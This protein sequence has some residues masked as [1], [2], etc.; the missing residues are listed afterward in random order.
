VHSAGPTIEQQARV[1][2]QQEQT[3]P[4]TPVIAV[5]QGTCRRPFFFLH[6]DWTG[7]AFYCFTLARATG[8][9]QPFYAVEP[10]KIDEHHLPFS[11]E[12]MAA[13]HLASL[14]AVQP[15][16]PYLLGGFCN[17]GLVAY[18]MAR[19]LRAEGEQVDLLLVA[20]DLPAHFKW[21]RDAFRHLGLLI[22]VSQKRQMEWFLRLRH[23]Q[24]HVYRYVHPSS[25]KV[26]GFEKVL[27]VDS[28]L[29]TMFPAG[30]ALR[31][32]YEGVLAWLNAGYLPA[33]Y[34][35]EITVFWTQEEPGTRTAWRKVARIKEGKVQIMPGKHMDCVTEH[36][37]LLAELLGN[38]LRLMQA[39]E[40][41]PTPGN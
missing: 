31:K 8:V 15:V 7:G 35:D 26:Q 25:D 2:E 1:L 14:R 38:H 30:E 41:N 29:G 33:P 12:A 13:A 16:G 28:R 23:L 5:Q 20:P 24:R 3:S 36:I 32:D 40:G 34:P 10:Y 11:L 6:G 19:Q 27:A 22:N 37:R 21:V 39:A 18:E 9:D 17:G 4:H